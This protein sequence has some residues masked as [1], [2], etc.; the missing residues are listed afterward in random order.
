LINGTSGSSSKLERELN[1]YILA[2]GK[3]GEG[4]T[5]N[6][7]MTLLMVIDADHEDERKLQ[8][9]RNRDMFGRGPHFVS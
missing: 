3:A 1:P 7:E 5:A 2:A 6:D 8:E 4:M 9:A